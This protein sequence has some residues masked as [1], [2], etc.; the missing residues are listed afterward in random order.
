MRCHFKIKNVLF[1]LPLLQV[2]HAAILP[3]VQN[4]QELDRTE[5]Q[6]SQYLIEE[7]KE[8]KRCCNSNA[9]FAAKTRRPAC[10][11]IHR[12]SST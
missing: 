11:Q 10:R 5:R 6:S 7:A 2:A 12:G 4:K 3:S 8:R 9:Q 1:L